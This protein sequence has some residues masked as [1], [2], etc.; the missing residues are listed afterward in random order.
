MAGWRRL[1][2]HQAR[3]PS[4]W[5]STFPLCWSSHQWYLRCLPRCTSNW[6]QRHIA[7]TGTG[8]IHSP[9]CTRSISSRSARP[10][11]FRFDICL[12]P[13][14]AS[15]L[16]SSIWQSI[17]PFTLTSHVWLPFTAVFT[18]GLHH[19]ECDSIIST[20]L[21]PGKSPATT[22]VFNFHN[23]PPLSPSSASFHAYSVPPWLHDD[24]HSNRTRDGIP[25]IYMA[26]K[27]PNV[28]LFWSSFPT[29]LVQTLLFDTSSFQLISWNA[30]N[31]TRLIPYPALRNFLFPPSLIP[32][33]LPC[34]T[35]SSL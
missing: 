19:S 2:A 1:E 3:C 8:R 5:S 32:I 12:R 33:S 9:P 11:T 34:W 24:R 35:F 15:N 17:Y 25:H 30:L 16:K 21:F 28:L 23:V 27:H 22:Y 13:C 7:Y 20:A 26:L 4:R 14:P 31:V 10:E 6:H 29:I 18:A